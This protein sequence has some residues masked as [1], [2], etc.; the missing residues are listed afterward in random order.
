M[1]LSRLWRPHDRRFWLLIVLNLLSTALTW[2]MRA[3]PL[4][5]TAN[6]VAGLMALANAVLGI[7]VAIDLLRD[8]RDDEALR[9]RE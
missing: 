7:L 1:K 2:A 5:A 6:T 4:T 3:Y 8:D 9:N